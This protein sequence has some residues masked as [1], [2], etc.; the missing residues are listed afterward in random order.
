VLVNPG[1]SGYFLTEYAPDHAL[2]LARTATSSLTPVERLRLIGDEWAM[3]RAGRHDVGTYLDVISTL[4]TDTSTPVVAEI[5]NRVGYAM[6]NIVAVRDRPRLAAWVRTTFGPPLAALGVSPKP[7][8]N[9]KIHSRRA[10][11]IRLV[12]ATAGDSGVH[13]EA[14]ALAERYF[15]DRQSL[16]GSLVPTVLHL[17][18]QSGDTALY[19]RFLDRA[20]SL[21]GEPEEYYRYLNALSSFPGEAL[22]KRTI[23]LAL[24]PEIRSQDVAN[25]TRGS[26]ARADLR[27]RAWSIVKAQW[28]QFLAKLDSFQGLRGVVGTVGAFCSKVEANDVRSFFD[29]NPAPSA[30]RTL[31]KALEGVAACVAVQ[32]RQQSA[33]TAW[34]DERD[35]R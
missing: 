12:G 16:P 1:G 20:R 11:L 29:A 30:A 34:L 7:N 14:R 31:T 8:D 19:D 3:V 5:A 26:I 24:S 15:E 25:L 28:P 32:A 2:A 27:G 9:D 21:T 33:L 23:D 18:A 4:A 17:A 13:A 10:A 6:S 22:M 35:A